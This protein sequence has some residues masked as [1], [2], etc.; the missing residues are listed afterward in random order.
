MIGHTLIPELTACYQACDLSK[1]G[2]SPIG[3]FIF[4]MKDVSRDNLQSVKIESEQSGTLWGRRSRLWMEQKPMLVT[5][6][7][8]PE[9]PVYG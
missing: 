6:L 3:E 8:L 7:F 4:Q 5:E 1:L 2:E 9:S